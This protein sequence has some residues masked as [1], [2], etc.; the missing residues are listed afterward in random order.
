MADPV[1]ACCYNRDYSPS[2]TYSV[3]DTVADPKP[4]AYYSPAPE[5]RV[6]TPADNGPSYADA[7]S[8]V[9]DL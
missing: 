5:S 7:L 3:D 1:T 4:T 6:H 8:S 2:N 9:Y